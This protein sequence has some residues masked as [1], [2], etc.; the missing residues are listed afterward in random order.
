MDWF[1]RVKCLSILFSIL[2]IA[3]GVFLICWPAATLLTVCYLLGIFMIL[4]GLVKLIGYFSRKSYRE[5]FR[6]DLFLGILSLVLGILLCCHPGDVVA[7]LQFLIGI[8]ILVDSVLKFQ[9]ALEARRFGLARWWSIFLV[10]LLSAVGGLLLL[11]NPFGSAK[12]LVVLLG[13]TLVVDGAQ[14]LIVVLYTARHIR[15]NASDDD[16]DIVFEE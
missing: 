5:A 7:L 10:A 15:R 8:F 13:I 4:F 6:F 14:N 12:A 11:L 1:K 3:L 9:T 16:F 2:P